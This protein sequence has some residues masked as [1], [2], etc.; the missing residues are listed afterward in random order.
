[1]LAQRG[2]AGKTVEMDKSPGGA[3][4]TNAALEP[5]CGL[6]ARRVRFNL[7]ADV[8]IMM[9]LVDRLQPAHVGGITA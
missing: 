2:S 3:T 7:R 6:Q 4:Q 8:G 5:C 9:L 1:M